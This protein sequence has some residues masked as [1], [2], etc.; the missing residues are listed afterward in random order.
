MLH[1][2]VRESIRDDSGEGYMIKKNV[3]EIQFKYRLL[4]FII[5]AMLVLSCSTAVNA[6][7]SNKAKI[8]RKN[9]DFKVTAQYGL[10]GFVIYD[11]PMQ[12]TVSIESKKNFEGILSVVPEA[13]NVFAYGKRITIA[14]GETKTYRMTVPAPSN[15]GTVRLCILN[16]HEK[17]I[18]EEKT[19]PDMTGF[20]QNRYVGILSDDYAGM[21]YFNG[22]A[23]MN[24]V[25]SGF[26]SITTMEFGKDTFPD[27]PD[28]LALLDFII[29]DNFDTS[30]LSDKQYEAIRSWTADGGILIL[31][32]GSHYQ[33]VLS[34]FKDDLASGK[35]GALSKKSLSWT[36]S[37]K[38]ASLDNVEC[39]DFSL[40]DGIYETRH[41][42]DKTVMKKN[43]GMGTVTVLA[44]SL[45]MEPV[46]D[47]PERKEIA[48]AVLN[49]AAGEK[50]LKDFSRDNMYSE[51]IG[52]TSLSDEAKRPSA[53]LYGLL[54][55]I[56]VVFVGPVLYL[57]LKKKNR[58][59]RIWYAIPL[60]SLIFTGIIYCTSFIYRVNK[61]IFN[62]FTILNASD[63]SARETVYTQLVCPSAKKYRLDI[64]EGYAGFTNNPN[65]YSYNMF[66]TT[67]ENVDDG[68][69]DLMY[70]DNGA[71]GELLLNSTSAFDS[72]KFSM[73]KVIKEG[74]GEIT[75]DLDCKKSGF[76]GKVTNNTAYDLYGVVV[77]YENL[78]YK[79][80]DIKKG[81]T[82][83]IDPAQVITST[84]Y[85]SF[86]QGNSKYGDEDFK[87]YSINSTMESSLMSVNEYNYNSGYVWGTILSYKPDTF[88]N[89]KVKNSGTAIVFNSFYNDYSDVY[90]NY[91]SS[92]APMII[93]FD[94]D[95]VPDRG[96]IYGS[97][98]TVTYSFDGYGEI[99]SLEAFF[100]D[101]VNV[102]GKFASCEAYNADRG[103][104]EPVFEASNV[105]SGE[106]LSKY[107]SHGILKLKYYVQRGADDYDEYY[108]PRIAAAER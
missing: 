30:S 32:L 9:D 52:L 8:I 41:S 12:V 99:A 13:Y 38:I 51:C 101:N 23:L 34:G 25:N 78:L 81:Q 6:A 61:P 64:N 21:G 86:G 105:I 92:I 106:E 62:S 19:N 31:S 29:I 17:L 76:S 100:D 67:P 47:S 95:F 24:G 27:D 36:G 40:D 14:A 43:Y 83:T 20:G 98:A 5:M 16:E 3:K 49:D 35:L 94:G 74:I 97:E 108:V 85:G 18:Y 91:Y 26:E 1:L 89:N 48:F 50:G 103:C 69:Y 65:D 88:D 66:A 7:G 80:G 93:D 55:I 104:F 59:E 60:T 70:L 63:G 90:G 107:L 53:I 71:N 79:A 11:T 84:G 42:T 96:T 45:S 46:S 56:Y 57:I 10:S 82:I 39:V 2:S 77:T 72:F 102:N 54:L 87:L 37:D 4:T 44:Y 73:S 58:R 22:L 68:K 33:N 75:C 15:S 28:S